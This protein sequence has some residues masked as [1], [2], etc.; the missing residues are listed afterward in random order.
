MRDHVAA[1]GFGDR[2]RRRL[3]ARRSGEQE[4]DGKDGKDGKDEVS[5]HGQSFTKQG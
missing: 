2:D 4:K 5:L 3:P 1:I